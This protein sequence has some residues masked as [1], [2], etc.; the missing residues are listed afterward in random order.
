[1][2]RVPFVPPAVAV[3]AETQRKIATSVN[4]VIEKLQ[5]FGIR[6]ATGTIT[7]SEE[8]GFYACDA[9]AAA[10]T[11]F[12][13]EAG[14]YKGVMFSIKKTDSSVNAVLVDGNASETIDGS[15][16]ATLASQYAGVTVI[17]TGSAWLKVT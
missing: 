10:M 14:A 17:S 16:T 13:P 12:L 2:S 5:P 11:V 15:I 1:M 6:T 8:Y 9:S 7:V 3:T 4:Q